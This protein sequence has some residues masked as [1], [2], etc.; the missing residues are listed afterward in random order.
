M[1]QFTARQGQHYEIE[2]EMCTETDCLTDTVMQL[3]DTDGTTVLEENDDDAA[4]GNFDSFIEWT[5]P[6]SGEYTVMVRA[7]QAS[8]EGRFQVRVTEG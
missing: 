5:C 4:T 1:W 7:F 6:A 8:D 3:I 2:T